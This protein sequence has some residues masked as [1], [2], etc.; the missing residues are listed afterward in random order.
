MALTPCRD[1]GEQVGSSAET[2][3]KCGAKSPGARRP[4]QWLA[5]RL[6]VGCLG[7]FIVAL[8]AGQQCAAFMAPDLTQ[9]AAGPDRTPVPA[10]VGTCVHNR[11]DDRLLGRAIRYL[12]SLNNMDTVYTLD[13]V[14]DLRTSLGSTMDVTVPQNGVVRACR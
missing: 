4:P 1:C 8:V 3:P 10:P 14:E 13:L 7:L 11:S 6:L 2:C 5:K 9:R 12:P